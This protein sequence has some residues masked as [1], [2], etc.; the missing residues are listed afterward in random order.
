MEYVKIRSLLYKID[1]SHNHKHSAAVFKEGR[2]LMDMKVK[3]FPPNNRLIVYLG[4]LLHDMCDRKYM[5]E[6]KG[7]ENIRDFLTSECKL[8]DE[9]VNAV[10]KIIPRMSY[11]KTIKNN[12]F[13]LP[14]DLHDFPYIDEYHIIRH[15]DLLTAYDLL[16]PIDFRYGVDLK[17]EKNMNEILSE[18]DNIIKNRVLKMI[19]GN[20]FV[21]KESKY[22]AQMYHKKALNQYNRW[23]ASGS[24]E[25]NEIKEIFQS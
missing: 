2:K 16:R 9:I 12:S 10:T 1:D 19:D 6:K 25:Y 20:I 14:D 8:D 21:D 7:L 15:A 23:K 24:T 3:H 5:D 4:C 17:F 22:L 18:A 13:V 11:S